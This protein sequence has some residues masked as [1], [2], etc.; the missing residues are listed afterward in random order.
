[1]SDTSKSQVRTKP[2]G[3]SLVSLLKPYQAFILGLLALAIGSNALSLSLPK[4]ISRAIDA[5]SQNQTVLS[6]FV[7]TFLV[8]AISVAVLA[9]AQNFV[10]IY[11]SE[12]VARDLR[13]R[14]AAKI[15]RQSYQYIQS[16]T[17]SKLLTNL[18]SD[19]DAIKL[20][21]SQ[22]IVSIASSI[23]LIIGASTLLISIN[24]RLAFATLAILPL[25]AGS[26][27]LVFSKIGPL[28]GRMQQVIDSLNKVIN[29]S[30]LGSALIRVLHAQHEEYDKFLVVNG[31]AKDVGLKVLRLFASVIPVITF[32]S[33]LATI[34]ILLYGGRLVISG[35]MTLGELAAFNGYLSILIFPI[36]IIGFMSSA[37]ARA[38][39][40]YAR[41]S[42][43]LTT[44]ELADEGE[45]VGDLKGN[46]AVTDL[47]LQ[48][49]EKHVLKEVSFNIRAGTRTAILG[50]TAAGKT[51]LLALLTGLLPP[52]SGAITYDGKPLAAYQKKSFYH[53]VS[54]VFQESVMFNL[55]VRENIAL[56]GEVS[57]S[58]LEKAIQTAELHDFVDALPQGLE[59][60]VSERGT[61]L[62]GGQKQRIMLARALAL[63]PKVLF[64][65][66]F[67][68]RIDANT[69]QRIL[70]N[71]TRNYPKMTLVSVTQKIASVTAFDQIIL[72]ME[73]ETIASG[74]HEE[75]MASSPEY[76]Q[77]FQS[78]Q[79]TNRYE[80]HATI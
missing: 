7:L 78:Q 52:T 18:T 27:Y 1:M 67:T 73:G 55:S 50:P 17:P 34:I 14:V 62:S 63:N 60:S 44:P 39:A 53:Q 19:I 3:P 31:H 2:T 6:T 68:A 80:E 40:S 47:N 13:E 72:L 51:Q 8:L 29:E 4:I 38:S 61:S 5:A 75:L 23:F 15:S 25:I 74:I 42:E 54:L 65:D 46:I 43:V 12:R 49:G 16:V 59:T 71:L 21:V 79:S 57:E 24:A 9:Y 11:T 69:E 64:L 35:S 58:D 32:L 26:F 76:V 22:A 28:F 70:E 41:I 37:I 30:I 20:F 48:Y 77:I 45:E 36:L 33:S 66:D 10:Q 56:R